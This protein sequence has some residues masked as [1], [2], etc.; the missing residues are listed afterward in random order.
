MDEDILRV[1]GEL[2]FVRAIMNGDAST[3]N[4][5]YNQFSNST[6]LDEDGT[7]WSPWQLAFELENVDVLMVFLRHDFQFPDVPDIIPYTIVL[8]IKGDA[9]I[10][11]IQN[12]LEMMDDPRDIDTIVEDDGYETIPLIE[13][14]DREHVDIVKM[15]VEHG[16]HVNPSTHAPLNNAVLSG[17]PE[18][19]RILLE[20]GADPNK[21]SI[22][23]NTPL[24]LLYEVDDDVYEP[25]GFLL[26]LH[27]ARIN[28]YS[29]LYQNLC[30]MI[31]FTSEAEGGNINIVYMIFQHLYG[32]IPIDFVRNCLR[33]R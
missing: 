21:M 15:L 6:F 2:A 26:L 8:E 20:N 18:L 23:G 27:G 19:V 33:H 32:D 22:S 7:E 14:I 28:I 5:L 4:R 1:E 16:A 31:R 10:H 11:V 9:R 29:E 12:L 30:N 3:V 17:D 13:A 24:D 25:I